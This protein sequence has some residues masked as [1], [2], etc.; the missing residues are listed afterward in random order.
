MRAIQAAFAGGVG[1][2]EMFRRALGDLV[3]PANT[4]R[5][6]RAVDVGS[7]TGDSCFALRD[8][9]GD[10]AE[11]T[12]TDVLSNAIHLGRHRARAIGTRVRLR[13]AAAAASP[14]GGGRGV[15]Y[16]CIN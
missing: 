9:L 2:E 16:V 4:P 6:L 10:E 14:R 1:R 15:A 12:G 13:C 3:L 7:G 11:V 8:V 5:R